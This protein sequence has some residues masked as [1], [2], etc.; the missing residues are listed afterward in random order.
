MTRSRCF[1]V[2]VAFTLE[3]GIGACGIVGPPVAP[4]DVGVNQTIRRQKAQLQKPGEA[5]PADQTP[6]SPA[7]SEPAGP[8]GQDE[9][10]P[11]LRPV[12]T[13]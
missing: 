12:G 13:R 6:V 7:S 8:R 1:L 9:E 10:L 11:F 3:C 5:Q 4:E 2:C